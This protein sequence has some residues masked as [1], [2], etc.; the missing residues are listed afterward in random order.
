LHYVVAGVN[1]R[2]HGNYRRLPHNTLSI[3]ATREVVRFLTNYA[4]N[5]AILL[6]GRIP[7]YKRDDLQLLP[8]STTKKVSKLKYTPFKVQ[9]SGWIA[10]THIHHYSYA[11]CLR[12]FSHC[13]SSLLSGIPCQCN[14]LNCC[15]YITILTLEWSDRVQKL[16]NQY[17]RTSLLIHSPHTVL[18]SSA[19][20]YMITFITLGR[21]FGSCISPLV[22]KQD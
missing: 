7:G 21:L 16:N 14:N 11:S 18:V 4:E 3:P 22:R 2:Q 20:K 6:P 15:T 8:S 1:A 10:A 13:I 5:H 12:E 17:A 9:E 19:V